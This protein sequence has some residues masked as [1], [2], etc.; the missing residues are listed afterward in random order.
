MKDGKTPPGMNR[1]GIDLAL[2][3]GPRMRE[4]AQLGGKQMEAE[5][6]GLAER[7][8]YMREADPL[9]KVPIPATFKGLANTLLQK[10]GGSRPEVLI[11]KLG[12]RLA[13]ERSGTR[14]YELLLARCEALRDDVPA[15][16]VT[17]LNKIHR[18]EKEH[19][20][21][22]DSVLRS[23][24]AD[25]T[26][27]TPSADASAVATAGLVQLLADPRSSLL[28]CLQAI[29]IAELADNAA[30]DVLLDLVQRFDVQTER[31][32]IERALAQEQQHLIT[33]R[34]W[35]SRLLF[36]AAKVEVREDE[37]RKA[38]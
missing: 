17:A 15:E 32:G 27:I 37:E 30:W 35:H 6:L 16:L 18:E 25:P 11:D 13:F 29:Q 20:A 24:G 1:T 23:L 19:F 14:L 8:R 38:V 4:N 2:L 3:Q 36:E 12:E 31:A 9:G 28:D 10:I 5:T 33:I 7:V 21:L 22:V 34:E 26:A